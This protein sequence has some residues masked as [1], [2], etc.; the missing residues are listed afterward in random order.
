MDL[1]A[2]QEDLKLYPKIMELHQVLQQHLNETEYKQ[3]L[4]SIKN[5][6]LTAFYTPAIVPKTLYA[7]LQEEGIQPKNLYEPSSGGGIF[8]AEAANAFPGLQNI[9]AVEKDLL[10]GRVLAALCSSLKVPVN[11]NITPFEQTPVE[12]SNKYDVIVSN[13]P[14]GNFPIY[15]PAYRSEDLSGKIHNYFFAKGLDKIKE[16]GLLA[17]ITTDAFLNNPSNKSARVYVFEEADFISL[18]VMP[19]NLMKDTGNTEAPSHLLIVQ[20]NSSKKDLSADEELLISTVAQE[21]EFGSYHIN[22]YI[23]KHPEVITGHEIKAGT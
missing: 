1:N 23:H 19:D 10:S 3:V 15:D 2:S 22:K 13:I 17:Y 4:D 12:E 16:G 21:N 8:I 5:S 7:V 6:V 18:S 14:F 20:K 9:T 11:V